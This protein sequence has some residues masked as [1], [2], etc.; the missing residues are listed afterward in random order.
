M[1]PIAHFL[2][3]LLLLTVASVHAENR[4]DILDT[5]DDTT[6]WRVIASTQ[7]SGTI[8]ADAGALCLDYNFNGVS[9]YVGMQRDVAI[10]YPENYR[11]DFKLRGDS[12]ANDLQ[13][14]LIDA[15]GDNVWWVNRPKY[16]FPR[17]W[18]PVR[19][20]RRHIGKAWGP[21]ADPQLRASAKLEFT[22]NN[23]AGGQGSVCFDDLHFAT[24]QMDAAEPRI[25]SASATTAERDAALAFDGDASTHWRAGRDAQRLTL[26]LGRA[27]EFGGLRLDWVEAAHP[28]RYSVLISD[29]GRDWRT[30]RTVVESDGGR[31]WIGLP[32][33]EA[34]YVAIETNAADAGAASKRRVALA[35]V[36]VEPLAFAATQ[37][38]FVAA[39]AK[40]R[41]RGEF[42]RGFS[43]EQAYWT[44][45]GV[46]GGLEQGLIGEDGAVEVAKGGFSIEPFVR[47]DDTLL[48]WADVAI[49]Q[50][51][52]DGYLP[53]PS[54]DWTH[55]D[56]QLRTTAF[57]DSDFSEKRTQIIVRYS[58]RNPGIQARDYT[59]ALAVQPFQVNPPS[60]FLNTTGGVS[61]IASLAFGDDGVV[62][63]NGRPR[64]YP[65]S[66][67]DAAFA[68]HFDAG[69][70][71]SHLATKALPSAT[72]VDDADRTRIWG[73]AV[74]LAPRAGR[75]AGRIDRCSDVRRAVL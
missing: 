51:L 59:L 20:K 18:A 37:N 63:V 9:G 22:L 41:P 47:V 33:S 44:I 13:F 12:P 28:H 8:R 2:S 24:L 23:S 65:K 48:T 14:K 5:F 32:E 29:D 56:A 75:I 58:L 1:K 68:T 21:G 19:Y 64:V 55:P 39:V 57:V 11:F 35:E 62:Q 43:G 7:V 26:D 67:P 38:D 66:A 73:T 50:S 74:S 52:Q 3:S 60:Q 10:D 4:T 16:V 34:R 30:L 71:A 17:E 15:S 54:V 45:L 49:S 36:R 40:D 69:M 31:D 53:I 6:P 72:S 46:D 25:V 27:T 42:P 70:A 61:R